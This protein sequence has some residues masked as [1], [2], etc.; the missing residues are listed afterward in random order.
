MPILRKMMG[1]PNHGFIVKDT[2][3]QCYRLSYWVWLR[4]EIK[5]N[6][7][8]IL[9]KVVFCTNL[10]HMF[11]FTATAL[12]TQPTT[13]QQR[14]MCTLKNARLLSDGCCCLSDKGNGILFRINTS[15]PLTTIA[16]LDRVG[17]C[18]GLPG[19]WTSHQ[20]TS[21]CGG[22]IKAQIYTSPVIRKR[23]LLPTLL[24]QQQPSGKQPGI[25]KCTCQWLLHCCQLCIEF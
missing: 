6:H 22:H 12:N 3:L 20:W 4:L 2:S 7:C 8:S 17:Q 24:W 14:L 5:Q 21:S 13:M 1:G 18:L 23:I 15:P 10:E 25:F 19:H 9:K 11:K 16:G